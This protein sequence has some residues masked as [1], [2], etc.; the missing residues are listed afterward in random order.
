MVASQKEKITIY[1]LIGLI[2]AFFAIHLTAVCL[3]DC[4]IYAAQKIAH[5]LLF[6][7]R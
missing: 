3:F 7:F 5:V 4:R 2:I 1:I 6:F